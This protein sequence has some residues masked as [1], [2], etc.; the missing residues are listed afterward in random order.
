MAWTPVQR[1]GRRRANAA[2]GSEASPHETPDRNGGLPPSRAASRRARPQ[3]SYLA[4]II[5]QCPRY[6]SPGLLSSPLYLLLILDTV[7]L[8]SGSYY[9]RCLIDSS[10]RSAKPQLI[11]PSSLSPRPLSLPWFIIFCFS[12]AQWLSFKSDSRIRILHRDVV[13]LHTTCNRSE[14]P[15]SCLPSR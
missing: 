2:A 14:S 15:R 4:I 6:S 1:A 3:P 11:R 10:I 5:P 12:T 7:F 9:F 8:H 13:I